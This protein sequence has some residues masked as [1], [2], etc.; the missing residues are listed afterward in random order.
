MVA[1]NVE[2]FNKSLL[3]HLC[4]FDSQYREERKMTCKTRRF[5][6]VENT[7]TALEV[8]SNYLHLGIMPIIWCNAGLFGIICK[9]KIENMRDVLKDQENLPVL[10][11]KPLTRIFHWDEV[12]KLDPK[13]A[14]LLLA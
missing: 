8:N 10:D 1:E 12:E 4:V 7:C 14:R 2:L 13:I 5:Y 9:E 3:P 11:K 6:Y